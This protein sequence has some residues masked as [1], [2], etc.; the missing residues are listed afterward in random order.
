M[1]KSEDIIRS[2]AS[3]LQAA[4]IAIVGASERARWSSQIFTNLRQFG[5]GGRIH[6]VN[7]RQQ[8]VSAKSVTRHC[9]TSASRSIMPW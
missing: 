8:T 6:L 1:A 3:M 4:S 9:A 2:P 7:P 5:Y